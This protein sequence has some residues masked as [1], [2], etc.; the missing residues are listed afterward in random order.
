VIVLGIGVAALVVRCGLLL[1]LMVFLKWFVK[2]VD[3]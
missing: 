2:E 3:A 1:L